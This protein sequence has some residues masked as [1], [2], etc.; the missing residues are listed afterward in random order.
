MLPVIHFVYICFKYNQLNTILMTIRL[1]PVAVLASLLLL[2]ACSGNSGKP[3]AGDTAAGTAAGENK[4]I[5]EDLLAYPDEA[6][7]RK[8]FG[9][10]AVKHDTIWGPE[11]LFYMGTLLFPGTPDEVEISWE[12]TVH[13]AKM[14][15]AQT[16]WHTDYNGHW[17][18][19]GQWKSATGV[20]LGSTLK[21]LEKINE[22]PFKFYGFGW[23]Y[24]GIVSGWQNGKLEPQRV[25]VSLGPSDLMDNSK[26]YMNL[27]GDGEFTSNLPDAQ[28]MN[29]VV[30]E[31][32]VGRKD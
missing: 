3:G 17:K 29:P 6:A 18:T 9:D 25:M 8:Q 21:E 11:G 16:V 27:M 19:A 5:L 1:L 23:D 13:N 24:S 10:A 28:T 15:S 2:G 4:Y 12:D 26:A 30:V 7:L 20:K 31:L 32:S 14:M 22:G